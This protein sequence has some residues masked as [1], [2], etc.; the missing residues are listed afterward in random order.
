MSPQDGAWVRSQ[1]GLAHFKT[2]FCMRED[3]AGHCHDALT[4]S[5]SLSCKDRVHVHGGKLEGAHRSCG[6]G[7]HIGPLVMLGWPCVRKRCF[8][9]YLKPSD[10]VCHLREFLAQLSRKSS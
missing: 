7:Q 6:Q 3:A 8:V 2:E 5:A 10:I 4:E 1:K 9:E